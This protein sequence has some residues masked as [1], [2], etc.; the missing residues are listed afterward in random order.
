MKR[1]ETTW[2]AVCEDPFWDGC[3]A[4]AMFVRTGENRPK[5]DDPI[6]LCEDCYYAMVDAGNIDPEEW[7]EI[8]D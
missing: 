6:Y 5:P 2:D 3:K 7:E 8:T 1:T 4:E